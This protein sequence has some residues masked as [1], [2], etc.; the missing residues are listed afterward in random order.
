MRCR[1]ARRARRLILLALAAGALPV[2]AQGQGAGP[3]IYG[4]ADVFLTR[5]DPGQRPLQTRIDSSA[6][7]ASRVGIRGREELGD[8]MAANYT[9]E[10]GISPDEG[11][12]VDSNRLFN[13]QAWVGLSGQWGELRLGRQNTP[14]FLMNGRFDAFTSATQAS[15]WNNMTSAPPRADA[16]VGWI[17]RS[18]QGVRLQVLAG[19]GALG[20]AAPQPQVADRRHLQLAAEVERG[21]CYAG[22]NFQRTGHGALPTIRRT[23][24]GVNCAANA[25]WRLFAVAGRERSSAAG[26]QDLW[27][28]SLSALYQPGVLDAWS[29]GWTRA[30][31]RL[32]GAGH[33]GAQ[34]QGVMYRRL[35]SKRT[36]WY[37]TASRLRQEGQRNSFTL[38]GAGV[39]SAAARPMAEPGGTIRGVQAGILHNF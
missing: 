10:A 38:G 18:W 23:F 9:L 24:L 8:G 14:Q 4:T 28:A 27:V 3:Q 30:H 33:G 12:Q 21:A 6:L 16:A 5:I 2:A 35:V 39:V 26:V 22:T 29:F 25:Q 20:G 13:R 37:A 1:M 7:L 11:S 31:D 32:D 19:R 34:Q 36:T 15:G 17:S